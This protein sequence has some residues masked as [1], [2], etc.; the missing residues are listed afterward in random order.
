MSRPKWWRQLRNHRRW[1]KAGKSQR[2]TLREFVYLDE[3]SVYS[4]TASQVGSIVTELTETQASSLQGE[5]SSGIGLTGPIKAEVNSR[6]Q[7]T[8]VQS[9]QVLR[10]AIIQSTFKELRE[11]T[12]KSGALRSCVVRGGEQVP[13]VRTLEEVQRIAADGPQPW[14]VESADLKRGRLIEMDVELEAE[15]I[16]RV[17]AVISSVLDIIQDDSAA[18][19]INDLGSLG[20]AQVVV[21]LLDKLLAGL[22]PV[23]GTVADY[24]AVEIDGTELLVHNELLAQLTQP[25]QARPVSLVGVAQNALFWKDVRQVLF[26]GSSYRVMARLGRDGFQE[27]WTPVKLADVVR[28][29]IPDFADGMDKINQVLLPAFSSDQR[30]RVISNEQ[31]RMRVAIQTYLSLLED[32]YGI[33][34]AE[35]DLRDAGLTGTPIS[36]GPVT[37]IEWRRLMAPVTEV[38]ERQTNETIDREVAADYRAAAI[39]AAGLLFPESMP[40]SSF[41]E[42]NSIEDSHRFLDSE[43]VAVYW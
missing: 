10:K 28:E 26:S 7:S 33:K 30:S 21:R 8:E 41:E 6:L 18:L 20:S 38:V 36:S 15:P 31:S 19:G 14:A 24:Q 29:V 43:L 40:R 13:E 34:V 25:F 1:R 22:V 17:A 4:L 23:R 9:A 27:S 2:S 32:R 5:I 42:A 35:A 3:V 16:F 12:E 39:T 37:P 11:I